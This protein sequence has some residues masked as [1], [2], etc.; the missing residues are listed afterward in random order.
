[1]VSSLWQKPAYGKGDRQEE[2]QQGFHFES[3][4][5]KAWFTL[6]YWEYSVGAQKMLLKQLKDRYCTDW[7][8]PPLLIFTE[9]RA[10]GPVWSPV[11]GRTLIP[12][13]LMFNPIPW[14]GVRYFDPWQTCGDHR[15]QCQNHSS[16]LSAGDEMKKVIC[17]GSFSRETQKGSVEAMAVLLLWCCSWAALPLQ[18]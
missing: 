10:A 12:G 13:T 9:F 3:I 6:D 16:N 1:M 8:L 14:S 5:N 17:I 2:T 11:F 18:Q 4:I 7:H 15:Q